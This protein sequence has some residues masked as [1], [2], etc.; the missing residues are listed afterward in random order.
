MKTKL[1]F[2]A[3]CA[4]ACGTAMADGDKSHVD[5]SSWDSDSDKMVTQQE[6]ADTIDA[7]GLFDRLDKNDNGNFDAEEAM[8]GVIDYDVSMDIDAGGTISRDEFVVGLYNHYDANDDDKLDETEWNEFASVSEGS[9][10]WADDAADSAE[11]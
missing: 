5:L 9:D 10:L 3:I 1:L 8:E 4:A 2:S 11:N 6:W 7:N